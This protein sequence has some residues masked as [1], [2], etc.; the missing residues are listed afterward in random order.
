MKLIT[1]QGYGH[2]GHE[3]INSWYYEIWCED[4]TPFWH[5]Y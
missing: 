3:A 2:F 5:G 4:G 1:P